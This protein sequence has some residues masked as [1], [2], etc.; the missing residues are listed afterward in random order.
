MRIKLWVERRSNKYWKVGNRDK[1]DNASNKADYQNAK[2]SQLRV[3]WEEVTYID[4]L[5]DQ[6]A[7]ANI[8]TFFDSCRQ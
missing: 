7:L 6:Y 1:Y 2:V 3:K 8:A 4:Q 5:L